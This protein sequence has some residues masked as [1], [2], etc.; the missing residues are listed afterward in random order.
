[1][2]RFAAVII[3]AEVVLT[4]SSAFLIFLT[5]PFEPYLTERDVR[6][7]KL[8]FTNLRICKEVGFNRASTFSTQI[9]LADTG[10]VLDATCQ[11]DV[12]PDGYDNKL[13]RA[14]ALEGIAGEGEVILR[15]EDSDRE[16]GYRFVQSS[17][18]Y[19]EI[20]IVRSRARAMATVR[21][22]GDRIQRPWSAQEIA[23]SERH[24]RKALKRLRTKLGWN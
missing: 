5:D 6:D 18:T 3:L 4:V 9:E 10:Q 14:R 21:I 11:F 20:E 7:L 8:S 22:T 16:R 12:L 1:M 19:L 23:E 17:V 13:Q 24:A 2:V 15:E